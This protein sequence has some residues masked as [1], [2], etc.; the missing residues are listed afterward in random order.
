MGNVQE[1]NGYEKLLQGTQNEYIKNKEVKDRK[2]Q[3]RDKAKEK[4]LNSIE[5]QVNRSI[6]RQEK[7]RSKTEDSKQRP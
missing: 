1:K 2:E 3:Q 7:R 4:A 6:P 5:Q